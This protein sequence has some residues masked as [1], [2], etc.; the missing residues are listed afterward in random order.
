M[1]A[2]YDTLKYLVM[3]MLLLFTF[4]MPAMYIYSSYDGLITE[5]MSG[6][7]RYS[8]GNMGTYLLFLIY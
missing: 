4:S 5:P 2:Y 1:N 7:T 3:L 8:L 6:I